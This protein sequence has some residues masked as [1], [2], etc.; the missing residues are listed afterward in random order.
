MNIIELNKIYKYDEILEQCI[1]L[2]DIYK[3]ILHIDTIGI[4][5]DNR[6]IVMLKLGNCK[7]NIVITAGVHGR[8]YINSAV[9]LR[10]IEKYCALAVSGKL[11]FNECGIIF[12]PV[13]NPDGYVIATE[14]FKKI[15]D[16]KLRKYCKSMNEKASL[17]KWN[18]RAI[19]INRNF[20]SSSYESKEHTGSINSENETKAFINLVQY[21]P[22]IGYLDIHSRGNIIYYYR[23]AM[24]N[25]YNKLQ[26]KIA[27]KLSDITAYSIMSPSQ[28]IDVGDSGGNTVHY[29][30]EYIKRPS[31]TIETIDDNADFPLSYK[32]AF[33]VYYQ[34]RYVPLEFL[35]LCMYNA[36]C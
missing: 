31:I 2:S 17:W 28:E 12:V 35:H 26:K 16:N 27:A 15:K 13:L 5:H 3:K 34:L 8:E 18:S 33:Q 14:G 4:S 22:T 30:S 23:N 19:D 9:L 24:N 11:Y 32:Y 25:E 21:E 1:F 20:I 7:K 29:Y 6:S 36:N 10:I